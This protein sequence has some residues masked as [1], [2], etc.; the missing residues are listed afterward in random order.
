MLSSNLDNRCRAFTKDRRPCRLAATKGHTCDVHKNYFSRWFENH[1][2]LDNSY[3]ENTQSRIYKEYSTILFK[4]FLKPNENYLLSVPDSHTYN[5]YYLYLCRIDGVNP[6]W[7]RISFKRVI[8]YY[9]TNFFALFMNPDAEY[10]RTLRNDMISAFKVLFSNEERLRKGFQYVIHSSLMQI[11]R[12][13]LFYNLEGDTLVELATNFFRVIYDLDVWRGLFMCDDLKNICKR[14]YDKMI[15]SYDPILT[16]YYLNTVIYFILQE[17][18]GLISNVLKER[19]SLYKEGIM[20][21]AWHPDRVDR[22]L[23]AGIDFDSM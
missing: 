5:I 21:A 12:L 23:K 3:L 2:P 15:L 19:C 7:N 14:V 16:D 4:G 8:N 11:I 20:I 10:W 9:I 17:T 18:K 6:L 1:E 13:Q 22:L